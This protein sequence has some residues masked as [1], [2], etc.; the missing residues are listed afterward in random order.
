MTRIGIVYSPVYKRHL[1]KIAHCESPNRLTATIKLLKARK[2]FQLRE[3]ELIKPRK[4]S[5]KE[6]AEVHE[7]T[8][9]KLVK[10]LCKLGG[11]KIDEDTIV[12]KESFEVALYAVGGTLKAC[13]L[14]LKGM[15][16]GGF[17]LIRPPGHHVGFRGR[18]MG[19]PSQ[20][21][22]IFNNVALAAKF[23]MNKNLKRIL[24]FDFDCHHGNGTQEIFNTSPNVLYISTHQD[25]LTI[26]PG[27]G[28]IEQIGSKDGAGFKVNIPLPP[29]TGDDAYSIILE[30]IVSPLVREFK[31]EFILVSA[32]YDAHKDDPLTDMKLSLNSFR[33]ICRKMLEFSSRFCKGRLIFVL[34]GGYGQGLPEGIYVTLMELCG[35]KPKIGEKMTKTDISTFRKVIKIKNRLHDILRNFW[36]LN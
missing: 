1:A 16:N 6:L 11:G 3:I 34:E 35:K 28:F 14:A 22:C 9:I 32:G 31:P 30:D 12:S 26:Y 27:T 7:I 29:F 24:I 18:A 20:G 21:F 33:K 8:Y 36:K 19:A 15:I 10:N 2:I 5:L 23:L 17:A 4:S 13:E 25:P